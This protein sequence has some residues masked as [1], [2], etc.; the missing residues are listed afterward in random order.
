MSDKLLEV[1]ATGIFS[2]LVGL[3][4]FEFSKRI[5]EGKNSSSILKDTLFKVLIPLE[6]I[7]Y[8][9]NLESIEEVIGA[10]QR[11]NKLIQE[12]IL[13]VPEAHKNRIKRLLNYIEKYNNSEIYLKKDYKCKI[14]KKYK[15]FRSLIWAY[16]NETKKRL[17]YQYSSTY[18][19]LKYSSISPYF[20]MF[21]IASFIFLIMVIYITLIIIGKT[22]SAIIFIIIVTGILMIL[23]YFAYKID[24][25]GGVK[26]IVIKGI[27][28]LQG[29]FNKKRQKKKES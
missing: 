29:L 10:V 18:Q 6:D 24:E 4:G 19:D 28:K 25:K 2:L 26:V 8:N 13:F 16:L 21:S 9:C 7:L 5:E 14:I 15:S 1:L 23:S 17:G 12:N 11:S 20:F 3:M 27:K 22:L